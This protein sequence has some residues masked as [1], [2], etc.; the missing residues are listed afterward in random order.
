MA[1]R[2]PVL[3]AC[4]AAALI[5][6]LAAYGAA[7]S[8]GAPGSNGDGDDVGGGIC[9]CDAK[10]DG[11]T[12]PPPDAGLA[13]GT[14]DVAWMH[15]AASCAASSDPEWQLHAY[16]ATTFILRGDKCRN[17]EAPFVYVLV[18]TQSALLLDTGATA[19]PGLRDRVRALVG[20]KPLL[21]AHTHA[22]GDHIASDARFA[23][24]PATTVVGTTRAAVESTFGLA[25]WPTAAGT[26]DLGERVLD[27][28]AIPGHEGTHIAIY[29]RQTGL[30]LTGDTLYPGL[31]FIDDWAAY[32]TSVHRLAQFARTHVISHVLGSHIEMSAM[33]G[34]VYPYGTTYQPNEH[35]LQL[36]P[37][38]LDEL[39]AALTAIGATPR[40][41]VHDDFVI[42]PQ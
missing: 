27:V 26:Y 1:T 31:L 21:V 29:D 37:A 36:T 39:D 30:F 33:P 20:G 8:G 3:A 12:F 18:G 5:A 9:T 4:L 40:R 35:V 6:G 14:L 13:E 2:A 15:G 38:H 22:H 42:D 16:N 28:L 32:R 7:C 11:L 24:Q 25:P 34:V 41:E 10:V 17:F 23:G 19:T